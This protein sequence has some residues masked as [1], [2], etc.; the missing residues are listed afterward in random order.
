MAVVREHKGKSLLQFPND[1]TIIDLETTGLTP[2]WDSIIE[3]S[4]LK[5][6]DGKVIEEFDTLINPEYEISNFITELTGITNEMLIGAPTI[7]PTL[8]LIKEFI[9]DDIILGHN[10]NFDINFLYDKLDFYLDDCLKNDFVDTLRLSRKVLP[11]L[12]H[13]RLCDISSAL[14]VSVET[15]HRA[16][17][18][19]YT[20]FSCY[21]RLREV[22]K[23]SYDNEDEFLAKKGTYNCCDLRKLHTDKQCFDETHL[24]YKKVCVFTGVLEKMN[25]A[26]AAQCVVDLGGLCENTV[27]QRTN[28]LILGNNEYCSTIKDG[29]SSKQKKAESYKLKGLDI[30]I[31]S[32]DVFYDLL[33]D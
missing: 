28:F 26:Q 18:D 30:E 25:R 1:F 32:E 22:I 20:T 4:A 9:G 19:C 27:T 8:P 23:E 12:E 14:N 21:Q 33:E 16:L 29:K 5:V 11:E 17:S 15:A 24:L 13:H 10:V 6:R 3:V 31:L 2:R 7:E